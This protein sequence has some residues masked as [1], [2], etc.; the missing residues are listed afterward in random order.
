MQNFNTKIIKIAKKRIFFVENEGFINFFYYEILIVDWDNMVLFFTIIIS[1]TIK[2]R[3]FLF[4][5]QE[6]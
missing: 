6:I 2:I 5:S 4:K 1:H 3:L